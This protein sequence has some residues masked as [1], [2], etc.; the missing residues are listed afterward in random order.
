MTKC[1]WTADL[2]GIE[3][4]YWGDLGELADCYAPVGWCGE[5]EALLSCW[6]DLQA[7]RQAG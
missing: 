7:G 2:D 4:T 1:E 5:S 3:V 6:C